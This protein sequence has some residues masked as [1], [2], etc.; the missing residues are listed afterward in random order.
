MLSKSQK[1]IRGGFTLVE[2]LITMGIIA[3]LAA[4]AIPNFISYRQR[5]YDGTARSDAKNSYT[6]A[7]AYFN[8]YSG[9]V[10]S[11]VSDVIAYGYKQSPNIEFTI[12]GGQADLSIQVKHAL[13]EQTYTV[14]AAGE[15]H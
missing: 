12:S 1:K 14:N 3:I 2:L 6:A 13:G 9:K 10:M 4:V 7:Q 11:D 8:D 15:I 5:G